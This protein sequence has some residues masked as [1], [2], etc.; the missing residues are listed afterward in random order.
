MNDVILNKVTII[1]RCIIRI[2]EVYAGDPKNL[3]DFTK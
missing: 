3:S 2:H 1:E